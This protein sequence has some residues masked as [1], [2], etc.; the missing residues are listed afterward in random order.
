MKVCVS[1]TGDPQAA[2]T[3]QCLNSLIPGA[4]ACV[5]EAGAKIPYG[6]HLFYTAPSD[7]FPGKH[8][9]RVTTEGW[10]EKIPPPECVANRSDIV[11]VALRPRDVQACDA[12]LKHALTNLYF[13]ELEGGKWVWKGPTKEDNL[14]PAQR[15]AKA[16]RERDRARKDKRALLRSHP[17][18]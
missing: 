7:D 9:R 14:T 12:G 17:C 10:R 13:S 1:I 3:I 5:L 2:A 8:L 11:L 16:A 4:N 6:A 18:G 15:Q